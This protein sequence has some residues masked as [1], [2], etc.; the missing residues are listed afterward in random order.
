MPLKSRLAVAVAGCLALAGLT[1]APAVAQDGNINGVITELGTGQ[2]L[3]DVCAAALDADDP[4]QVV[5]RGCADEDGAYSLLVPGGTYVVLVEDFDGRYAPAY[6]G[7]PTLE[8]AIPVT[9]G[10]GDIITGID[11]ALDPGAAITGTVLEAGTDDPVE[12]AC[13]QVYTADEFDFVN[14]SCTD[15]SGQFLVGGLAD[16]GEY[17]VEVHASNGF[18]SQW[19]FGAEWFDEADVITAPADVDVALVRGVRVEGVLTG[20]DGEPAEDVRVTYHS[21]DDEWDYFESDW[22]DEDGWWSNVLPA[23]E[24]KVRFA[25]GGVT[26]WAIGQTSFEAATVFDAVGG[27]SI[28]IEDV[29]AAGPGGELGTMSGT[30][31]AAATGAPLAGICADVFRPFDR[32][33]DPVAEACTDEGGYYET[34][35]PTGEYKVR[36]TDPDGD[37]VR[38]YYGGETFD[39]AAEVGVEAEGVVRLDVALVVAGVIEGQVVDATTRQPLADV[40]VRPYH[41]DVDEAVESQIV[42]CSDEH[43]NWRIGG[44]APGQ[45][46]L[47]TYGTETHVEQWFHRATSHDDARAVHVRSGRTTKVPHIRLDRG[48]V[49]TGTVTNEAGEPIA[50]ACVQINYAPNARIGGCEWGSTTA[51][52]GVYTIHNVPPGERVFAAGKLWPHEYATV[53]NGGT[54]HRTAAEPIEI[55]TATT[56]TVDFVLPPTATISGTVEMDEGYVMLN[57]FTVDG[58]V[59]GTGA[60]LLDGEP[61]PPGPDG[62]FEIAGLPTSTVLLEV[63]WYDTDEWSINGVWWYE[64]SETF[65]EATP[66]QVT[67]GADTPITITMP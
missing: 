27:D 8:D 45:V 21:P 53:W 56:T 55:R 58:D 65:A 18:I 39:S 33:D 52:D 41:A 61:F 43:G 46:K 13:V 63:T 24:F 14:S 35:V 54:S 1:A 66:I 11:V 51:A 38:T 48:A 23:G 12:H 57:A 16:G 10:A 26:R 42:A 49:V 47:R 44:L 19:L 15:E 5:S 9:V 60:D 34:E 37:Y 50:G 2:P 36:F 22:T 64:I 40:C 59:I 3:T 7:G 28:D 29:F 31:T 17:R 67:A 20:P 32:W 62:G 4:W 30:V 6:Y 25:A